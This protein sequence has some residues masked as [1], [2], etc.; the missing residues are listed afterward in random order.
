MTPEEFQ[1]LGGSRPATETNEK[2]SPS[3]LWVRKILQVN[4]KKT[5]Q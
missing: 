4:S 1:D 2:P 5:N 3:K